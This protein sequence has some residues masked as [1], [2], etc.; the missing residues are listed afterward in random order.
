MYVCIYTHIQYICINVYIHIKIDIYISMCNSR[1][2]ASSCT[3]R[4]TLRVTLRDTLRVT[5]RDTLRDTPAC[6][7]RA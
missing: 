3:L 1:L 4:D 5:L 6:A 2:R 7:P